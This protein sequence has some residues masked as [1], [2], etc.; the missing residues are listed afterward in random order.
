MCGIS[1]IWKIFATVEQSDIATFNNSMQHRGPDGEAYFI[2]AENSLALGHRRLALLDLSDKAKQPMDYLS[3]YTITFNGEIFN[4]IEL[5]ED[6]KTLGYTFNSDSDTEVVLAAYDAW[7]K[8]C[9]KKFNGMWAFALWDARDKKMFLARDRFGVKPL[10]YCQQANDFFAFASETIAFKNLKGYQRQF[11]ETKLKIAISDAMALEGSGHTIFKDI[12][13]L[14]PGHYLE[15]DRPSQVVQQLRWWNTFDNLISPDRDYNAQVSRFKE[16][17]LDACKIRLRSDVPIATALSG[18]VDSTA[19]YSALNHLVATKDINRAPKDC[20]GAY[21]AIFPGSANDEKI[22]AQAA[23]DHFSQAASFVEF[24]Q[25]DLVDRIIKSTVLFDAIYFSPIIIASDVYGAMYRDG[26]RVSLD[27]HGA[28]EMMYGYTF[29]LKDLY[30]YYSCFDSSYAKE[31]AL[32]YQQ[33]QASNDTMALSNLA[34]ASKKECLQY[35][36]K[37]Y[38]HLVPQSLKKIYRHLVLGNYNSI[39]SLSNDPYDFSNLALPERMLADM[40]HSGTLPTILR[41]FDRASMQSSIETRMP[42][43]DYRLV[44]YVFSLPPQSKLGEGYTKRILR[45]A[46]LGIMSEAIRTRKSKIGLNAPLADWFNGPL[47]KFLLDNVSSV[48]F[49]NSPY[50]NGSEIRGLVERNTKEKLWDEHNCYAIW[51][52]INAHI[53]ITNN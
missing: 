13:Q 31:I 52:L 15:M 28:D 18:G 17:F 50:W 27:G 46:M 30:E 10:Y 7:G 24:N 19:V 2:D 49:I 32:I 20:H 29:L 11:D 51:Q 39:S 36:L 5:R 4:F 35:T 44:Q 33:T 22:F 40:F 37:K 25:S 6:L 14:L 47:A 26:I 42:F 9:L 21:S 1:G 45:D 43:M 41:N 53:L 12:Y 3:R 16:L 38:Y 48:D 34:P 8:D 23:A